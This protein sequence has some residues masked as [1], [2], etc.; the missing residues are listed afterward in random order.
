MF[1][2][3]YRYSYIFRLYKEQIRNQEN[4][5]RNGKLKDDTKHEKQNSDSRSKSREYFGFHEMMVYSLRGGLNVAEAC[6]TN[7]IVYWRM[8][9][10]VFKFEI[11]TIKGPTHCSVSGA[12][13]SHC[14]F[15]QVTLLHTSSFS[16]VMIL[17]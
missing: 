2:T 7:N 4:K 17:I 6:Q 10:C 5:H 8:S 9:F 11:S 16:L 15:I 12:T 1:S 14:N 3:V 13:V